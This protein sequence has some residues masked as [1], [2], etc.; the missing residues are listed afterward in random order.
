MRRA[1]RWAIVGLVPLAVVTVIGVGVATLRHPPP[2]ADPSSTTGADR[3]AAPPEPAAPPA[4]PP[5][6]QV[7]G[8]STRLSGPSTPPPGAIRVDPGV[9]GRNLQDHTVYHPPGTTFW[10]APG[11]HTLNPDPFGQVIPK[12]GNTYVGSPGAILDGQR[13]NHFAFTQHAKD[14]T[15]RYLT[16]QHFGPVGTNNDEGVVN[17]DSGDNWTLEYNTI[18]ENAGA[19]VF[20]GT[21]STIRHNCLTHNGQYGFSAYKPERGTLA[22]VTF[23]HNEVSYNNEDDWEARREG[24]GCTGGGK[25]WD[26]HSVTV[27]NNW[28]HHNKGT[29]IWADV[30]NYGFVIENNYIND[31]DN[32]G[33]FYEV[34]YNAVIRNNTL[35]R[36]ALVKGRSFEERRDPFPVGA[37]YISESGG[38]TR[39]NGGMYATLEISNNVFLNNWDGVVLWENANRFCRSPIHPGDYCTLANPT[40]V[41]YNTCTPEA[42]RKEPFYSDCR[43]KTQNVLVTQN[44]FSI[45]RAALS[46]RASCGRQAVFSNWGSVPHW[47]PYMGPVIQNSVVFRQNNRFAGNTYIGEWEFVAVDMGRSMLDLRA[48][49][50][51]PYHQDTGSRARAR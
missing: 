38:D 41:H 15:I 18:R 32:E 47:S 17:H 22:N 29:G 23:E 24:C 39:V 35:E 9:A 51:S 37:I 34:S 16:I 46:C 10:L 27:S 6:A 5:P 3:A 28:V 36:N 49:Q 33:I 42:I 45:D 14:V 7:C 11:T 8:D 48:W 26:S 4:T 31:N 40:Q 12:D 30:N 43:W 19:G 1:P 2:P 25:F 13:L 21:G 44:Y 20:I 50:A